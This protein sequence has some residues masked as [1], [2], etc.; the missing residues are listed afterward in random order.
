MYGNNEDLAASSN[1]YLAKRTTREVPEVARM[2]KK[3]KAWLPFNFICL[4]EYKLSQS[5]QRIIIHCVINIT[6]FS[7]VN[8]LHG[9][10][11]ETIRMHLSLA[12]AFT[13]Y[14]TRCQWKCESGRK[15]CLTCCESPFEETDGRWGVWS[16]ALW[17]HVQYEN[18]R[19]LWSKETVQS[20]TYNNITL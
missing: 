7:R 8:E 18:S 16:T 19:Q 1:S 5:R 4:P 3:Q 6:P 20:F 9:L 11:L 12:K 15:Q 2:R 17:I 13:L 14:Q 10:H